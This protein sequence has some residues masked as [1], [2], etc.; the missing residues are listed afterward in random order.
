MN[1]NSIAYLLFVPVT[2]AI[3]Y[4][5]SSRYRWFVLLLSS[6]VFYAALK[7]PYLFIPLAFVT[8]VS[9]YF[10]R[11]LGSSNDEKQKQHILT[12]GILLIL[13]PLFLLRYLPGLIQDWFH[14]KQ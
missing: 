5:T 3:F 9:F 7:I 1:L 6:L 8:L 10:G 11:W 2:F 4:L 12:A 14:F 13:L